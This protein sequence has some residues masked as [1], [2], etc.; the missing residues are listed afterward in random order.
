MDNNTILQLLDER[1]TKLEKAKAT[2]TRRG[3]V[4]RL[5]AIVPLPAAIAAMQLPVVAALPS[6][7]LVVLILC[8]VGLTIAILVIGEGNH[9]VLTNE[10]S[11]LEKFKLFVR[12][13]GDKE[14]PDDKVFHAIVGNY[15]YSNYARTLD[16]NGSGVKRKENM[17]ETKEE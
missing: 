17:S 5:L 7:G 16:V 9:Y 6:F 4:I 11:G 1:L 13:M 14:I 8:A 15:G 3:I 10:I 2:N 12:I